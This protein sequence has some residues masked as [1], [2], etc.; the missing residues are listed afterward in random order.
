MM[1]Q[2]AGLVATAFSLTSHAKTL[3]VTKPGV[4][5]GMTLLMVVTIAT[6]GNLTMRNELSIKK[7]LP[8]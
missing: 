7:L 1:S 8:T 2:R 6:L 5:V 4:S 3:R